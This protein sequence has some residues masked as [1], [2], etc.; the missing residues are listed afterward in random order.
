MSI[1]NNVYMTHVYFSYFMIVSN[2]TYRKDSDIV[3]LLPISKIFL[4][5]INA[6]KSLN[7]QECKLGI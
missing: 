2:F 6:S 4:I 7:T 3:T 1:D 5:S